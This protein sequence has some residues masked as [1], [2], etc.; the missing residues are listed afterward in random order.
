VFVEQTAKL[1]NLLPGAALGSQGMQ[2]Q[3]ARGAVKY[4]LEHVCGELALSLFGGLLRFIDVSA[5]VF[6]T[7]D[8]PLAGHD[9]HE[10][11]DGRVAESLFFLKCIMHV[12]D[13]RRPAFPKYL[14]DLQL[15]CGRFLWRGVFHERHHTTNNFVMSTKIFVPNF[16]RRFQRLVSGP[17]PI[18]KL[19]AGAKGQMSKPVRTARSGIRAGRRVGLA[20][21]L[22]KMGY[23]SRSAAAELILAGR[24]RLNGSVARN[25]EAPVRLDVDRI[26]VD[27]IRVGRSERVYWMLNKPRGVVTTTDDEQ[28]RETV[29]SGLPDGLP[30]M[31]PVGRLDKA[32]EG[33]LLFTNDS[34]WAARITAPESHIEKTYHVQIDRV[35]DKSLLQKLTKGVN[36]GEGEPLCAKSARV[37]RAGEKNSWIEIV[38]D[39][40]KNRQI[41]RMLEGCDVEVLRLIRVAIGPLELGPLAK[42]AARELRRGEKLAL[43]CELGRAQE[44]AAIQRRN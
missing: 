11:Q 24:V 10:F 22:S 14:Q 41:R 2:H 26:D 18:L 33:L 25:P 1:F 44:A 27:G 35:A 31:G 39:E 42:G 20:R 30:W 37:V 17:K 13:C 5:L 40:G 4:A 6:V 36:A 23:C 21:A 29:Y 15:G 16:G 9:L 32:S 7:A 34:E 3:V 43:D 38:L 12:A 28:G 19:G 8:K